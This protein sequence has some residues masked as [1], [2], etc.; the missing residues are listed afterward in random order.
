MNDLDER[1][2]QLLLAVIQ[3]FMDTA[4]AVGSVEISDRYDFDLSPATII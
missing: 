2:K 1:Q 4:T 3:E